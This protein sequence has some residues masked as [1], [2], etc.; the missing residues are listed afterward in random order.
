MPAQERRQGR[1]RPERDHGQ[2]GQADRARVRRGGERPERAFHAEVV[3]RRLCVAETACRA[4]RPAARVHGEQHQP[5]AERDQPDSRA[6][7]DAARDCRRDPGRRE[8]KPERGNQERLRPCLHE[9]GR[10]LVLAYLSCGRVRRVHVHRGRGLARRRVAAG[11]PRAHGAARPS[12]AR[13]APRAGRGCR[14]R[15]SR[16]ASGRCGRVPCRPPARR[17]SSTSPRPI[18]SSMW[19]TRPGPTLETCSSPSVPFFSSTKAPNCVVF[20]TLPV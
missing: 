3:R 6:A 10:S 17:T 8:G 16:S 19:P 7:V 1:L 2:D 9:N 20:T 4:L 11:A 13:S 5:R 18:T 14:S 12:P 15:A